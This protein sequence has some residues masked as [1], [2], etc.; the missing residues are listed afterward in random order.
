[1]AHF[2]RCATVLT[3]SCQAG[4][5][6]M[7]CLLAAIGLS[8]KRIVARVYC[9]V[10]DLCVSIP[11]TPCDQWQAI[12]VPPQQRHSRQHLGNGQEQAPD[13]TA[14]SGLPSVSMKTPRPL[15]VKTTILAAGISRRLIARLSSRTET[16]H[17]TAWQESTVRPFTKLQSAPKG[18]AQILTVTVAAACHAVIS[19]DIAKA[20]HTESLFS[21]V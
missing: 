16:P 7:A 21:D 13:S 5:L 12:S 10:R 18:N 4:S 11:N 19:D 3:T 1:M 9:R 17:C 14:A 20:I 6:C 2:I 8:E 15:C